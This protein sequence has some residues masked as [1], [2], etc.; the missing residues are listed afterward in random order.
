MATH[1]AIE[2]ACQGVVELLRNNYDPAAFNRDL[3][4]RVLA[5][6]A[7][8]RGLTAGVSLFVYRVMVGDTPRTPPGRHVDS[9]VRLQPQLPVDVH[10]ILTAWA[11]D[12]SLQQG[13]VGWMMRTM[14]DHRVLPPGLLNRL[15][16]GVF[17]DDETVE[18]LDG[19]LVSEDLFRLWELLGTVTYQI[20]VP[21]VARNIRIESDFETVSAAPVRDRIVDYEGVAR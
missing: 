19:E 1:R 11:P 17:R 13:I 7:F 4:F 9:G 12:A 16:P 5:A 10:F 14:D 6:S 8:Q 3:E 2:S 20:S 18:V 21:Y 15:S